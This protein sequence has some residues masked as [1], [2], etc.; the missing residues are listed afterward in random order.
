MK[1]SPVLPVCLTLLASTCANCQLSAPSVGYVRY[2]NDGVHGVYGLEGNYIVGRDVLASAATASFSDD[3]G[4]IFQ[5]G[6]LTLVDS[7][8]TVLANTEINASDPVVRLDG[9]LQTAIAWIPASRV[10]VHWNGGAFV[11]MAVSG[12][13]EE[14]TVTS[15]RKLDRSTASVL[16]LKQD[17]SVVRELVSLRTGELKTSLAIPAASGAAFEDGTR[18]FCFQDQKLSVLSETGE[19]LQVF[20]LPADDRLVIEQVS[21]QCLHLS[22]KTPGQDWLLHLNGSDLHLYKLPAP[23]KHAIP[24]NGANAGSEQ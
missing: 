9:N 13:S 11:G 3:G 2:A 20:S 19:L 7:K 17:N 12:I 6:S 24:A 21:N 22:T 14:D 16:V 10:L 5:S 23:R 1:L 15:V 18:I 4:L 8:L